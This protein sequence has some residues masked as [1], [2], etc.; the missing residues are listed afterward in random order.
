MGQFSRLDAITKQQI[1]VGKPETVYLLVPRE[2]GGGHIAE[3]CYDGYGHFGGNDV[4]ELVAKWNHAMIPAI[5]EL[6]KQ[7]LWKCKLDERNIELLTRYY[8]NLPLVLTHDGKIYQ[9]E[10]RDIGI[11]MACYSEDNRRL[12]YPIKITYNPYAA[13]ELCEPSDADPNQ[14]WPE[15]NDMAKF[16]NPGTWMADW[17]L[18]DMDTYH[19][20]RKLLVNGDEAYEFYLAQKNLEYPD[21]YLI[22]HSVVFVNDVDVD[23]VLKEYKF[24]D[25]EQIREADED[26]FELALCEYQFL[27]QLADYENIVCDRPMSRETAMDIIDILRDR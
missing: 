13:Y 23:R 3:H 7:D 15:N 21:R 20:A 16:P 27:L 9:K 26:G 19:L 22:A 5:L 6:N 24:R 18:L 8:H 12:K 17:E 4:Y 10:L 11:I 1:L 2:F 25:M 14:G